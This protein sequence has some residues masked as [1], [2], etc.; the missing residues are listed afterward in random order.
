M[1]INFFTKTFK[2]IARGA[3]NLTTPSFNLEDRFALEREIYCSTI[4]NF[5]LSENMILTLPQVLVCAGGCV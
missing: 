2:K 5:L 4:C 3:I 1:V